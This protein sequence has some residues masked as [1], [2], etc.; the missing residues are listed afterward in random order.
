MMQE[1]KII[2]YTTGVF[3]MLHKGHI[4]LLKKSSNQCDYLIV[5]LTTD[6]LCKYIKYKNPIENF[7]KRKQKIL[8]LEFVDEVIEQ[9]NMNKLEKCIE[10]GANKV[11]VGDDWKGTKEWNEYESQLSKHNI[12]TIYLPYTE[13]ISS[14]MIRETIYL[15]FYNNIN[16]KFHSFFNYNLFFIGGNLLSFIR[17][18]NILS[19]DPKDIDVAYLSKYTNVCDVKKEYIEILKSLQQK[20]ENVQYKTIHNVYRTGYFWWVKDK[21]VRVDIMV[22]WY[23][24]GKLYRATFV[25]YTAEI[26]TILPLKRTSIHGKYIWLPN[27]PEKVLV[28]E[29]GETWRIPDKDFIKRSS[30]DF[31]KK[32][33]GLCLNNQDINYINNK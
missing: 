12:K 18:G 23:E 13:G 28:G 30:D 2:G 11:F 14:T 22:Y 19:A 29:F 3:D 27:K 5:G 21:D 10:I 6:S 17:N 20:G 15:D 1:N 16:E 9:S 7:N 33:K 25:D 31:R 4:N 26:D 24:K 32:I 8:E